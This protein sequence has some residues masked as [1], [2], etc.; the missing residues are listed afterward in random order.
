[1]GKITWLLLVPLVPSILIFVVF[2]DAVFNILPMKIGD[3][4][5]ISVSGSVALYFCLIIIFMKY[6]KA[7]K[8]DS[9]MTLRVKLLGTWSFTA[10][11]I[12]KDDPAQ[13]QNA[14]HGTLTFTLDKETQRL[15]LEGEGKE[16]EVQNSNNTRH[17]N[18]AKVFLERGK[19]IYLVDTQPPGENY[20]RWV[21]E[22]NLPASGE[23]TVLYGDYHE[24]EGDKAGSMEIH[25]IK[26]K[27]S[28]AQVLSITA[29]PVTIAIVVL[30]WVTGALSA[31][32]KTFLS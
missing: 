11:W 20:R 26:K 16:D 15:Y 9:L 17:F 23:F 30:L 31:S 13:H 21:V 14:A 32:L 24:I 2:P 8:L 28:R 19:L 10:H 6:L 22:L 3:T 1:M 18:T 25:R 5:K 27:I 7:D 29:I 4:A 12:E